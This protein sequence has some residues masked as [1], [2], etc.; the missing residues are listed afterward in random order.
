MQYNTQRVKTEKCNF[1]PMLLQP[2]LVVFSTR[3]D[4]AIK[5]ESLRTSK[6]FMRE[7]F[8]RNDGQ[9]IN[10]SRHM[11]ISLMSKNVI[12]VVEISCLFNL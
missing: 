1:L 11:P 4:R 10:K 2:H 9:D 7:V 3:S 8:A 5:I 6:N 12:T